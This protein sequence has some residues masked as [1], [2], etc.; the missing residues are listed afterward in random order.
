MALGRLGRE[1]EAKKCYDTSKQLKEDKISQLIEKGKNS[2]IDG[3][4]DDAGKSLDKAT[5]RDWKNGTL[6]ISKDSLFTIYKG[7]VEAVKSLD[8]ATD[9]YS[10]N[11]DA[12]YFNTFFNY[13]KPGGR[14]IP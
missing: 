3:K 11:G 8:K 7:T 4:Y 10:K 12:W 1:A 5:D 2:I 9:I 13:S 14:K 6:G